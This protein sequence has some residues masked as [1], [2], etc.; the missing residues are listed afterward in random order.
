MKRFFTDTIPLWIL[1]AIIRLS[2]V[3][4]RAD[5][6]IVQLGEK[7]II[8]PGNATAKNA[9]HTKLGAHG[10]ARAMFGG[11]ILPEAEWKELYDD[12]HHDKCPKAVW[13]IG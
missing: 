7:R 12:L 10:C 13:L 3:F 9:M 6:I 1:K 11:Y 8:F 2:V 5:M 4:T